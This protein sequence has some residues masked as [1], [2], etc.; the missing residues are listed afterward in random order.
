M[1]V[2]NAE[3]HQVICAYDPDNPA[4]NTGFGPVASSYRMSEE[5][6]LFKLAEP[7]LRPPG[8]SATADSLAY[9]GLPSDQ[10]LIVRRVVALDTL[11]RGNLRSQALI[12][13]RGQFTPQVALGLD[14][15]DWPLG[16]EVTQVRLGQRLGRIDPGELDR[17]GRQG[18][19]RLR[20]E[21]RAPALAEAL[22]HLTTWVLTDPE[23]RF[24]IA[25]SEVGDNPRAVL[26]GLVD[27][28][29]PLVPGRWTFSTLESVESKSYRLIVMPEWPRPGSHNYGRRRLGGQPAPD[30]PA[31]EAASMLVAR[32]QDY[33]LDGLEALR[34]E[35]RWYSMAPTERAETLYSILTVHAGMTPYKELTA[36][37]PVTPSP[38]EYVI[39]GAEELEGLAEHQEA[40]DV[41]TPGVRAPEAEETSSPTVDP[42]TEPLS[43]GLGAEDS[44][45]RSPEAESRD[46]EAA[47]LV[48]RLLQPR[49]AQEAQDLLFEL[50]N[51]ADRWSES[52]RELACLTAL[53]LRLGLVDDRPHAESWQPTFTHDAQHLFDLLVRDA[54]LWKGPALAW[55]VFLREHS[56]PALPDPL[57]PVVQR[58]F[59]LYEHKCL[60]IH[61][62]FFVVMGR[63]AI[64][65]A[66]Q[67]DA[68]SESLERKAPPKPDRPPRARGRVRL[69][70][71]LPGGR[72]VGT[73]ERT[74][75][76]GADA[77]HRARPEGT[78]DDIRRLFMAVSVAVAIIVAVPLVVLV[79][80]LAAVNRP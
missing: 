1:P 77:G 30:G 50:H 74:P 63:W 18:A 22:R 72:R 53:R 14:H 31:H 79:L 73:A 70:G 61:P 62:V 20:E 26:L 16:D 76:A 57:R 71:W 67:L 19:A 38:A 37:P 2:S 75:R 55:A 46:R 25:A 68:L 36:G 48:E 44:A 32:Y 80:M 12:S 60:S 42:A 65:R 28:L 23:R 39:E 52:E 64:P 6:S 78:A 21:S 40:H 13:A 41:R 35:Q 58:M 3:V 43:P 29:S 33:G 56:D 51:S 24:S 54:L 10:D 69:T 45:L 17:R 15:A 27:M 11:F 66:L 49:T 8:D 59:E 4:R 5:V 9:E 47:A 34:R 7:I